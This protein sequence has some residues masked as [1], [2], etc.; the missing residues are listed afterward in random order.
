MDAAINSGINKIV[1]AS[2]GDATATGDITKDAD[3]TFGSAGGRFLG[4]SASSTTYGYCAG[5]GYTKPLSD[6][7]SNIID[8]MS[9]ASEGDSG[10][11]GDLTAT[12]E[13]QGQGSQ[14]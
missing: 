6:G 10:D 7:I 2:D 3:S 8:K 12:D 13:Y 4:S 1:F 14:Y 5:G 11:V 9:F